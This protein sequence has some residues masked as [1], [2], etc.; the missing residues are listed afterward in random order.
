[1]FYKN[2]EDPEPDTF[3]EFLGT[4]IF[5]VVWITILLLSLD[6]HDNFGVLG[7]P[8]PTETGIAGASLGKR[9]FCV[10]G[11]AIATH[12]ST[13]ARSL[14]HLVPDQAGNAPAR[15]PRSPCR[16]AG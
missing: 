10:A 2:H 12:D 13:N 6:L 16:V 7:K 8:E 5:A 11:T 3:G 4:C 14:Q 15:R 1:M 9:P